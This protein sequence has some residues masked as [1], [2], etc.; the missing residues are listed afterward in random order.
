MI[1]ECFS[2]RILINWKN[3]FASSR[4]ID[5]NQTSPTIKT[6]YEV[7]CFNVLICGVLTFIQLSTICYF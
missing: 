3:K 5:N 1:V 6:E 7:K 4:E 2:N